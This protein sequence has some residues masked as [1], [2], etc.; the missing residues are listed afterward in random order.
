MQ[1]SYGPTA[2]WVLVAL[3]VFSMALRL[4]I[5]PGSYSWEGG[6]HMT[7]GCR[8]ISHAEVILCYFRD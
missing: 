6:I 1:F 3:K 2:S 8:Q 5:L 7:G 4:A